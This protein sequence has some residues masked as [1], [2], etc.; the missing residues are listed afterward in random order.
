MA[1]SGARVTVVVADDHPVYREGIA[2]G[3]QLSGRVEVVAEAE[4]GADALRVI[5]E[6]EPQVALIDYRL[7]T[8]DGIAVVHALVRDHAPTR[9]LLL[10]AT[11]DAAVVYRAVQE[12]AAGY[13]AKD[14]RR[15]EIVDAVLKVA[16]GRQVVSEE[17][18]GGLVDEIR[19][20]ADRDPAVLSDRERQV[21]RGFA[22][23]KSIPQL[24]AEL[25]LGASTVK[26]HTQRLYEKLGVS[27]RAA[28]VAEAMRRGL[29]E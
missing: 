7:P 24:A 26:T 6:L 29:L 10:S 8:L 14:A 21:L 28:A 5:R 22:D 27:D 23:G 11:T 15:S 12:G 25:Y 18:A 17:L 2:R 9:V 1:D 4:D 3:L 19:M 16:S 13:L 20:R